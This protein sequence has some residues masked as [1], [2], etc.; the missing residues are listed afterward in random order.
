MNGIW[1]QHNQIEDKATKKR[2]PTHKRE[3]KSQANKSVG[4]IHYKQKYQYK[5]F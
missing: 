2:T 5:L 3:K 1:T 4:Q